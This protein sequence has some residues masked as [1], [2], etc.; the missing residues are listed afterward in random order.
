V[1]LKGFEIDVEGS[2]K[3][4]NVVFC[5]FELAS[6]AVEEIKP[7]A[8]LKSPVVRPIKVRTKKVT[9]NR[10]G[11]VQGGVV[12]RGWPSSSKFAL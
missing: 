3:I 11:V 9:I 6:D 12:S 5:Q 10:S 2:A 4:A 1:L 8:H 7:F